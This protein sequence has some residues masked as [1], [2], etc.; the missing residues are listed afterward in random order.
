MVYKRVHL[1]SF[2]Y[3]IRTMQTLFIGQNSIRLSS[4]GSTNNFAANLL[5]GTNVPD[6]TVILSDEQTA[7]RGQRGNLW[8]AEAGKNLTLSYVLKPHFIEVT[9]Q[10]AL[11]M[12]V[13][14]ALSDVVLEL[15]V[16]DVQLKWPNDVRIGSK[17][18]A[19]V[20]IETALK[21]SVLSH[22]IV[23]IGLN[24]NQTKFPEGVIATSLANV[25]GE[26]LLRED[27]FVSLN[28]RLEQRYLQLKQNRLEQ[29][30]TDY[31]QR[32]LGF[33]QMLPYR[34]EETGEQKEFEIRDVLPSG[35]VLMADQGGNFYEFGFK[36]VALLK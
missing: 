15:G 27:V 31:Q 29:L 22:A 6:G 24:V 4:V 33:H 10:F 36:E 21:G 14:L 9:D 8:H 20:L 26:E 18:V 12:V 17:K 34:I 1:R 28:L 2:K 16:T 23:G 3:F 25:L 11:S 30:K 35:S 13:A 5:K 19:G 32:L 7:G